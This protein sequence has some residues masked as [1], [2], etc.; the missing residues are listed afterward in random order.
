MNNDGSPPQIR[1]ANAFQIIVA[2][3]LF[4]TFA[5]RNVSQVTRMA[6]LFGMGAISMMVVS[7]IIMRAQTLT[8]FSSQVACHMKMKSMRAWRE[9]RKRGTEMRMGSMIGGLHL[10]YDRIGAKDRNGSFFRRHS[11]Y[12]IKNKRTHEAKHMRD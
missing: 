10:S 3:D 12:P 4:G 11:T 5:H 2:S 7:L 9:L 1:H 8:S 6:F